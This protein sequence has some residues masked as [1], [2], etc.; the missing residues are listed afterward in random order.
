MTLKPGQK[1]TVRFTLKR[2][3]LE[4]FDPV[5]AAWTA[6]PGE[7][8]LLIGA[9]SRDIRGRGSFAYGAGPVP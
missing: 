5:R 3:D 1:R 6:E 2:P 9:S 7:F 4:Y 8:E